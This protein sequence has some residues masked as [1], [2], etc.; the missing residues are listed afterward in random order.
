ME[1]GEERIGEG[2]REGWR[3]EKRGVR[4]ERDQET[5]RGER[6]E[7]KKGRRPRQLLLVNWQHDWE[8]VREMRSNLQEVGSL[9]QGLSYHSVLLIVQV[10]NSL[11]QVADTT[12]N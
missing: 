5:G 8:G 10:E 6:R 11:L 1:R 7:G 2:R 4:E 12:M 3:G 9:V